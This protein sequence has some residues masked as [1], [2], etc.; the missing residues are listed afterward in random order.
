MG[1]CALRFLFSCVFGN[2]SACFVPFFLYLI[3][4]TFCVLKRLFV[5]LLLLSVMLR[6]EKLF[7]AILREVRIFYVTSCRS[8]CFLP[9]LVYLRRK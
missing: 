8:M 2:D 6:R 7:I 1:F 4:M 3:M 5:F 9:V